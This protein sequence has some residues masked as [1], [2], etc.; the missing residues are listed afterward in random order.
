MKKLKAVALTGVALALAGLAD[1]SHAQ[2]S[3]TFFGML[4]EGINFTNNA[5]GKNAWQMAS[6]DL[7]TSRWGLKGTEDL[8]GG[9]SALFDLESGFNMESGTAAYGG[10][11]FGYQSYV[12]LQDSRLGSLTFGRQFDTVVDILG[13]LT[14]NSN[15]AGYLFAHPLDNDNTDATFHVS[16]AVKYTSGTYAG[17]SGTALYG[18]SNQAGGFAQNRVYSVGLNYTY[19]TLTI[20][21]AY[22]DLSGPGTNA[23]G[24][25]ASDDMG[26]TAQRQ[27]IWGVGVNYGIGPMVLGAV[28][29]HTNVDQPSTSTYV[30]ALPVG[31]LRFDNAEFNIKYNVTPTFFL[32][33]M[34]TYTRAEVTQNTG[35]SVPHWNQVGL[36]AQYNLSTRTAVYGQCVYQKVSG[37]T[38]GTVLDYAYI[39]GAAG[40]SSN[41]HQVI[42]RIAITHSF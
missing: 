21:A 24:T 30:G 10:R 2:S 22:E 26:F 40:V 13:P 41:S 35:E 14:A 9:L 28:Y 18:F 42:G 16:N 20:G 27:K 7:V 34:Y 3:V 4:D 5:G 23:G 36:M 31:G 8:G 33:G 38:T 17:L 25:V 37:G 15:W 29:T 6:I 19:Q 11:L 32:G 39:P 12:G 1:S